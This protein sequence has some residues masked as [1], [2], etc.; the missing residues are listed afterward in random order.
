MSEK[1][2]SVQRPIRVSL[3]F[4]VHSDNTLVQ[5]LRTIPPYGRA[6][7]LRGLIKKAW[8]QRRH[9]LTEST[10]DKGLSADN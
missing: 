2:K 10:V 4:G 6:K 3:R 9:A 5:E 7:F 8:H 1:S